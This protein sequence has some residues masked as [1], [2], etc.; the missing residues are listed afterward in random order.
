MAPIH[1]FHCISE[2]LP[3]FKSWVSG[4]LVVDE[5]L[6]SKAQGRRYG[7][8]RDCIETLD[9]IKL[10]NFSVG[11]AVE[12]K[13]SSNNC[14]NAKHLAI[15]YYNQNIP[16]SC[17]SKV[18]KQVVRKKKKENCFQLFPKKKSKYTHQQIFI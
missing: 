3:A 8:I 2:Q 9:S 1:S 7:K 6:F 14:S 12:D 11:T 4:C 17:S 15:N 13:M 18:H 5:C 16:Q 10:S